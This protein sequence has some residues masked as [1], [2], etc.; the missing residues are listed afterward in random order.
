[1]TCSWCDERFERYL[2][3]DLPATERGRLIEHTRACERCGP[4]LEELRVVDALLSA[5]HP[6]EPAANFT[7]A[8]MAELRALPPPHAPRSPLPAYLV[9]Y[10][11]G[12]WSLI[13]AGFVLNPHTMHRFGTTWLAVTRTS[14]VAIGGVLHVAAHLGDRGELSS[15]TTVAGGVVLLDLTLVVALV[16]AARF[17]P[18]LT[19]RR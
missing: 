15:W 16:A 8:T 1:M 7:A 9:C 6:V 14:V 19:E 5:P 2:D 13:A 10:I 17:A 4:L 3:G 11:V 12:A 18:R